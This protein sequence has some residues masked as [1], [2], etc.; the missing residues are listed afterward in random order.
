MLGKRSMPDIGRRKEGLEEN[1]EC[2][3]MNAAPY[4]AENE[5]QE[6]DKREGE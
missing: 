6:N 4:C 2:G 5:P 3:G 1:G